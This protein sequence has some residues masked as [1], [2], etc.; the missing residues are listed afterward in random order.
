MFTSKPSTKLTSIKTADPFSDS[1]KHKT[2]FGY[3]YSAGTVPCRIE[4]GSIKNK[5]QW[6]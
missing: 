3:A 4:H 5:L 2:N 1:K 6:S